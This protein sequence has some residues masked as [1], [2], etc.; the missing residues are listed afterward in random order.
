[1]RIDG[2]QP[3]DPIEKPEFHKKIAADK[4]VPSFKDTLATFLDD[5][6]KS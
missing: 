4:Q 3:G 6:N 2:I 5:V 1:M